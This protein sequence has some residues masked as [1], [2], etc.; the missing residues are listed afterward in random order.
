MTKDF[1]YRI[2]VQLTK[3]EKPTYSYMFP[4]KD[5]NKHWVTR[6]KPKKAYTAI[7]AAMGYRRDRDY[8]VVA[9]VENHGL[10]YMFNEDVSEVD[11]SYFAMLNSDKI[12]DRDWASPRTCRH[13]GKDI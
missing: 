12:E 9:D 1:K 3:D 4:T 7:L 6:V 10:I 11:I 13:C 2:F 8:A 5:G